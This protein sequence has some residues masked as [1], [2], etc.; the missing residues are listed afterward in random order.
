MKKLFCLLSV[1]IAAL[2]AIAYIW[3]P[4]LFSIVFQWFDW[5]KNW[6][7]TL[8]VIVLAVLLFLCMCCP[9][10]STKGK[11]TCDSNEEE[12]E[13]EMLEPPYPARTDWNCISGFRYDSDLVLMRLKKRLPGINPESQYIVAN[14]YTISFVLDGKRC[15][16]TVSKGLMT[17]LASVPPLFRF[18]AGRVG[19]HLEAC[20]VHDYLYVAWQ[21]KGISPTEDMR[22][23]ADQLMLEAMYAAGMSCKA[24]L[25]YWAVRCFGRCIF[26]RKDDRPLIL[27]DD[28]FPQC[29]S[30]NDNTADPGDE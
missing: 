25:I 24:Q 9:V 5:V 28:R 30:E 6:L 18:I 29:S 23:F 13:P 4:E 17:D 14:N 21:I 16:I 15:S 12:T 7:L 3:R 8:L 1:V 22:R 20:V 2:I 27:P 10:P 26:S 11:Q 19:P